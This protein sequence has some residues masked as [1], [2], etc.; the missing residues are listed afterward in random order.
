MVI[1]VAFVFLYGIIILVVFGFV[2]LIVVVSCLEGFLG[3][4]IYRIRFPPKPMTLS[5][6]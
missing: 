2:R 3:N 5:R 4:G 6:R 1:F